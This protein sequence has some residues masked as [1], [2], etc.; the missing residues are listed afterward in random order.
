MRC[1]CFSAVTSQEWCRKLIR[2]NYEYVLSG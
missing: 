2:L 1:L